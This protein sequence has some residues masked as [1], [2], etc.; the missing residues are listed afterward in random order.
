MSKKIIFGSVTTLL[1]PIVTVISCSEKNNEEEIHRKNTFDVIDDSFIG[2]DEDSLAI[3][4]SKI[5]M[6]DLMSDNDLKNVADISYHRLLLFANKHKNQEIYVVIIDKPQNLKMNFEDRESLW[7]PAS[8]FA[9]E[10]ELRQAID[11]S[12]IFDYSALLP[13][14]PK[15]EPPQFDFHSIDEE[16]QKLNQGTK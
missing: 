4:F 16:F 15:F 9:S 3:N 7:V 5:S 11:L 8:G 10:S 1:L 6:V 2:V 13:E 14:P 12:I